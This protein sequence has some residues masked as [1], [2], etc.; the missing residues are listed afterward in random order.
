MMIHVTFLNI[1]NVVKKPYCLLFRLKY[2]L[3]KKGKSD[4]VFD[5]LCDL[6]ST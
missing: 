5:M 1:S 6:T 2:I 3:G 4:K